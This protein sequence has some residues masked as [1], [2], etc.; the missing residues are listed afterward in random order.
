MFYNKNETS[1]TFKVIKVKVENN[2]ESKLRSLDQIEVEN[3]MVDTF[4]MDKHL[5]YLQSFL[6]KIGLLSNTLCLG[7]WTKI[8]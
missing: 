5:V 4:K 1:N 3:I 6:K 2:I 7:L 8:V